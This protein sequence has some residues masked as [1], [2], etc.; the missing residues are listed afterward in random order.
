MNLRPRRDNRLSIKF[1]SVQEDRTKRLDH[2]LQEK[3]AD[4]SRARL[5]AWIREGRVL[6]GGAPAKPSLILRAGEHIERAPADPPLLNAEPEDFP[7]DI[8]Y[9]DAAVIA[10]NK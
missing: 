2:F 4:Q 10:I 6:V 5:Q 7:I 3:L 9:E 8:L 1:I